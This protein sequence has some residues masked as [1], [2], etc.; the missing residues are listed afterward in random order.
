LVKVPGTRDGSDSRKQHWLSLVVGVFLIAALTLGLTACG[1]GGSSSGGSEEAT[2]SEETGAEETGAGEEGGEE[3][4]A[5]GSELAS[6]EERLEAAKETEPNHWEGPTEPVTP[7]KKFKVAGVTCASVLEGCL[8]PIEGAEDAAKELGWEFETYD[9]EGDPTVQAKRIQ[10]A[11]QKGANAIILS[12]VNGDVVKSA[13]KE[14]EAAGIIVVS[15]SNGTAPGEQGL[16]LDTSPNLTALGEAVGDWFVVDSGGEAV[17]APFLDN[18][19]QSNIDFSGG[20]EKELAKCSG[21][22]TEKTVNF[23]ATDVGTKLGGNTTAYLQANPDVGYFY[24]TYDPAM[25]EQ[26]AA[27][28]QAGIEVKSCSQL[29]DA[30][31]LSFIKNEQVQACDGAWD[32]EYEGYATIDQIIRLATDQPLAVSTN[33]PARYKYGENIPWVLLEKDNLPESEETYRAPFDYIGEY[34]KLWGLK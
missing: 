28:Q 29:G 34:Q 30:Q 11:V 16:Q 31:N 9:G 3:E 4:E 24:S 7:P 23:V 33:V 1:G 26:V 27:V 22:T 14:A 2:T 10:Q 32:N 20:I 13:L 12:A 18:E 8:T 15:T 19:F 25:A 5:G 17:V 21:C 6:F